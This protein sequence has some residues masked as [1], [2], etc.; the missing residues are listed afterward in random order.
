MTERVQ[1]VVFADRQRVYKAL[2]R[3]VMDGNVPA[4]R[5]FFELSGDLKRG[6]GTTVNVG[7]GYAPEPPTQRVR[8]RAAG[9]GMS[10]D[11]DEILTFE[12]PVG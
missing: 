11:E 12:L 6:Q 10:E 2:M 9:L 1:A 3:E 8:I 5:A 7:L 4:I